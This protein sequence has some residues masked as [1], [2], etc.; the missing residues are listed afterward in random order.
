MGQGAWGTDKDKRNM[1]VV[2]PC[3]LP[4]ALCSMLSARLSL[5][6]EELHFFVIK[7]QKFS[8]YAVARLRGQEED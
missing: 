7:R 4:Y 3:L 1:L 2:A 6:E 8:G 5:G